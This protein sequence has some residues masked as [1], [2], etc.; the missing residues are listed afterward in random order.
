MTIREVI[1]QMVDKNTPPQIARVLSVD[2]IKCNV[3]LL[4]DETTL[5]DVQLATQ[6]NGILYTPKTDSF[7]LVV[8]LNNV[9]G[10]IVSYGEIEN[11]KFGD[12]AFDGI[13]KVNDLVNKLNTLE[14]DLNTIKQVF[15]TF[16]PVPSDGG[17]ALKAAAATW[18][19]QTLTQTT[20][21]DLENE[22][23]THGNF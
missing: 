1:N 16:A 7:V 2:G 23:I 15:T 20:T 4:S 13:V 8:M 11:I 10:Y 3:E 21:Q 19:G 18:A 17:A 22:K 5:Y 14:S 12:G 9:Q 6:E